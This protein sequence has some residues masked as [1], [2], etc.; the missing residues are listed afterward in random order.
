MTRV[1]LN[2][3]VVIVVA[4]TLTPPE[5]SGASTNLEFCK[6]VLGQ[7]LINPNPDLGILVRH[8]ED[9]AN[10]FLLHGHEG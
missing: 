8:A 1:Q 3:F 4:G 10:S 5:P 7:A 9:I 2:K 6:S